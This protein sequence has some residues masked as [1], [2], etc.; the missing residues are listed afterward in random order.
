MTRMTPVFLSNRGFSVGVG[1]VTPSAELSREKAFLLSEG[2]QKCHD[3]I[4]KL[5]SG[6]LIAQPG[7]T[8]EETLESLILH[9]LSYIRDRA[10]KA[11]MDNLSNIKIMSFS[12]ARH[13]A[14]LVMAICGS[15]GSF[16]NIS[17]MIA[18][19]GQQAI[20]GHRPPNGFYKRSLPHFQ[21]LQKTPEAKGF[22]ENSFFSGLTPTEFYFHTMAGREGLVDTAVKT[23][24]TGYLQRRLVKCLEDLHVS[25]D[26]TVR[27]SVGDVVQFSFGEDGLDPAMMEAK[28]GY[29]LDLVHQLEHIRNTHPFSDE[30]ELNIDNMKLLSKKILDAKLGCSRALFRVN[31]EDF[32]EEV[33]EK[34]AMVLKTPYYCSD[35]LNRSILMHAHSIS[36]SQLVA[37]L[38]SCCRKLNKAAVEPGTAVGAIAATSIGEP[39][40]QMTLKSFHFAGVASMNITQGVPRIKEIINAISTPIITAKLR[41][42]RDEKLAR[43]VI[44]RVEVTTL[45]EICEYIEE[46]YV[47]D[48]IFLLL[49]LN[50]RR[51][52][53]LR[54]EVTLATIVQ[55]ILR[56]KCFV[57][58]RASQITTVGKSMMAIRPPTDS[59]FSVCIA[60]QIMKQDLQK[61]VV[62]GDSIAYLELTVASPLGIHLA[63]L[64]SVK[65][66]AVYAN[67]KHGD[68]C[69]IIAE[70]GDFRGILAERGVDGRF[71]KI[72]NP[73][74]VSEVLG[75]EAARSCIIS[76]IMTTMEAHGIELDRRHVMLLADAMTY[77]GEVLGMTRNGLV[78]MKDSVL[79]LASFEKT[80][81]HLF[82]AA[83]YSQRDPFPNGRKSSKFAGVSPVAPTP[84]TFQYLGFEIL[85]ELDGAVVLAHHSMPPDTVASFVI[86]LQS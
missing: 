21:K 69:S 68:E 56:T 20:S 75:I 60:V 51:I 32:V 11:C 77:R 27:S 6:Q 26:G 38:E 59:K 84:S 30:E 8:G 1:D 66:C 46:V 45:G 41:N 44:A 33:I 37:F 39:S 3:Y 9:E 23:A 14:A 85:E 35:H 16:I 19:V 4:A 13:N 80:V 29:V 31:L 63:G 49:K 73:V 82:E 17:Q 12:N 64:P 74:I 83:F 34:T 62:K 28:D 70:G 2:Y 22:V 81:D 79:L 10:G 15:K 7:C 48:K 43:Q 76:E 54:L 36:N 58:I 47:P 61:V 86:W 25:Y 65:R 53:I 40:T 72:N 55:S 67:E 50:T 52:R 42:V 18:C 24:E 5:D 71:T 78:K 57:P